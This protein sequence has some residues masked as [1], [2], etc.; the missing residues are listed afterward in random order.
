MEQTQ[1][2]PLDYSSFG[3]RLLAFILDALILAIPCFI[4]DRIIPYLGSFIVYF[5]YAPM[6][7][8]SDLRA[9][10]AKHLMGIQVADLQ[11]R[12][13]SFQASL[14]RNLVKL[15]STGILF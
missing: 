13:I 7:E 9:T 12:R 1:N 11:G 6:L 3:R 10:L 5:F 8:T 4:A 15:F 2:P 14:I